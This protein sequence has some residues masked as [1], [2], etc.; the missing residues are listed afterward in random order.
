MRLLTAA[1]APDE[2]RWQD[3][4]GCTDSDPEAFFPKSGADPDNAVRKICAACPVR[5]TC[6]VDAIGRGEEFG[7]WG[8]L[9]HAE[10]LVEARRRRIRAPRTAQEAL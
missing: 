6:L 8:G 10:R 3:L 2:H 5:E 7:V 4:G 9:T 1:A